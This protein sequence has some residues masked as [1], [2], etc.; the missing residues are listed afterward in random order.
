[1]YKSWPADGIYLYKEVVNVL[2]K[3]RASV[4]RLDVKEFEVNLCTRFGEEE[5]LQLEQ[6]IASAASTG[7]QAGNWLEDAAADQMEQLNASAGSALGM[8]PV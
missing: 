1:M 8:L 5:G 4:D 3:Q 6:G 7:V 2:K